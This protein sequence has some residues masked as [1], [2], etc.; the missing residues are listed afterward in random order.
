M[1]KRFFAYLIIAAGF[2]FMLS[3]SWLKWGNILI[4]TYRDPYVAGKILNGAVLYKDIGYEMGPLTPYLLAFIAKIFGIGIYTFVGC[5]IVLTILMVVLIYRISRLFLSRLACVEIILIFLM[6]FAIREHNYNDIGNFILPYSFA[7]VMYALFTAAALYCLLK[8]ILTDKHLYLKVWIIFVALGF[9][10]RPVI[11]FPTWLGFGTALLIYAWRYQKSRLG[12]FFITAFLPLAASAVVYL[13]YFSATGV[14]SYF[15]EIVWGMAKL[16]YVYRRTMGLY[17]LRE[18]LTRILFSFIWEGGTALCIA[19]LSVCLTR[20]FNLEKKTV[21]LFI[22][23][24]GCIIFC[25]FMFYLYTANP[26]YY[27]YAS[28]PL[29]LAIGLYVYFCR[30]RERRAG[31]K[32]FALFIL[33]MFSLFMNT[34]IFLRTYFDGIGYCLLF[35][36]LIGYFIFSL[37]TAR[38]IFAPL[39]SNKKTVFFYRIIMMCF[40]FCMPLMPILYSWGRFAQKS[41]LL[42]NKTSGDKIYFH[43]GYDTDI[44]FRLFYYIAG[45][46]TRKDTLTVV[47]EG[48]GINYFLRRDNPLRYYHVNP[49]F[50]ENIGEDRI[51]EEFSQKKPDV[52]VVVQRGTPEYGK[53]SFGKDYGMGLD[54]WIR[55]NYTLEKVFGSYPFAT[56]KFGAAFYRKTLPSLEKIKLFS[57]RK[58]E[59]RRGEIKNRRRSLSQ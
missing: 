2:I 12:R 46:T 14:F 39:L 13:V 10:A 22:P 47:P 43:P 26:N 25:N 9:L 30:M 51:V 59:S 53:R 40:L 49:G 35:S 56:K 6:L 50:F 11:S 31:K 34:R 5:G 3:V 20:R 36:S 37:Y 18:S 4:D 17:D 28:F 52:I 21:L 44:L 57:R 45:H 15:K 8:F 19:G 38:V 58:S 24:L 48:I 7:A 23:A 55:Q 32:D 54:K 33:F 41:S 27:L 29:V 16:S 42:I 1:S